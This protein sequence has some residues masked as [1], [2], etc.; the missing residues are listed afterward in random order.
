VRL[1]GCFHPL[2]VAITALAIAVAIALS[3]TGRQGWL[4]ATAVVLVPV[5]LAANR[6][7]QRR[8]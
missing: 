4:G 1:K 6:H 2:D 3:A 5:Y 7:V 8:G